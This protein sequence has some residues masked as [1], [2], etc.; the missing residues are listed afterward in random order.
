MRAV[1]I[2]P[3]RPAL[4]SRSMS[5]PMRSTPAASAR[6]AT[7]GSFVINVKR[8][9]SPKRA[10]GHGSKNVRNFHG[11]GR[12][13]PI[14]RPRMIVQEIDDVDVSGGFPALVAQAV[15]DAGRHDDHHG[16]NSPHAHDVSRAFGRRCVAAVPQCHLDVA[17]YADKMIDLLGRRMEVG[18]GARVELHPIHLTNRDPRDRPV[19]TKNLGHEA[20]A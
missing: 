19:G 7:T 8:N 3:W 12:Q 16:A 14:V 20:A 15:P 9:S 10:I 2:W 4:L 1:A 13:S 6:A 18:D 11:A 5:T 17:A